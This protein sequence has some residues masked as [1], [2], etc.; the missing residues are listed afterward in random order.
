MVTKTTEPE[1]L[2]VAEAARTLRQSRATIYRKVAAGALAAFKLGE[3]GP[4]RIPAEA[5]EAHLRPRPTRPEPFREGP[6]E[7]PVTLLGAVEGLAHGGD[8]HTSEGD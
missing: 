3:A 7:A 6:A 2:T 5:L 4:L 1:L 8:N